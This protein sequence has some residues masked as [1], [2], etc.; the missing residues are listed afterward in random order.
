MR[1][2][3]SQALETELF[4]DAGSQAPPA[5]SPELLEIEYEGETAFVAFRASLRD[6]NYAPIAVAG[7][8]LLNAIQLGNIRQVIIDCQKRDQCGATVMGFFI[9]V[10]KKAR[11]RGGKLAVCHLTDHDQDILRTMNLDQ[12]W[13]IAQSREEAIRLLLMTYSKALSSGCVARL[14]K[15]PAPATRTQKSAR[16]AHYLM[17]PLPAPPR[18]A[19]PYWRRCRWAAPIH[20]RP[21]CDEC[22]HRSWRELAYEC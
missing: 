10:W 14:E 8:E 21:R 17:L 19:R 22:G 1:S 11:R 12:L 3:P 7:T 15:T 16:A 4:P 5:S 9:E 6:L 13:L 18:R 20:R 2:L